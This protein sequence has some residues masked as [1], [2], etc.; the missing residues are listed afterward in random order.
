MLARSRYDAGS[1][2]GERAPPRCDGP[3]PEVPASAEPATAP[4]TSNEAMAERMR[5]GDGAGKFAFPLLDHW[6][7][8][9][10]S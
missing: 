8:G 5:R 4:I 10:S 6:M 3:G 9:R 7:I 2:R 1:I